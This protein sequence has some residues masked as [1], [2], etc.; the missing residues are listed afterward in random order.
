M[1]KNPYCINSYS[2]IIFSKDS[3]KEMKNELKNYLKSLHSS[4]KEIS[5]PKT[6]IEPTGNVFS[7]N[8]TSY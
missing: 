1:L 5:K 4:K 3:S 7:S 2:N 6:N 8:F